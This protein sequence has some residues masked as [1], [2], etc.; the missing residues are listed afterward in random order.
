M[1]RNHQLFAKSSQTTASATHIPERRVFVQSDYKNKSPLETA[2]WILN[3]ENR[4][5]ANDAQYLVE[6][7]AKE[8]V[9]Q[10]DATVREAHLEGVIDGL[11][12]GLEA[13]THILEQKEPI[14][15][16]SPEPL[17]DPPH[18]ASPVIEEERLGNA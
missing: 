12:C 6:L 14:A 15:S 17:I 13:F 2:L 4:L 11:R 5:D 16:S 9:K 10:P 1:K 7:L 8:I 18:G 3:T